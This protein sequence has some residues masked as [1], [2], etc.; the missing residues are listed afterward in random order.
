[1]FR[2]AT[3]L[4]LIDGLGS[5]EMMQTFI[6]H[7][8][9]R[10]KQGA[11]GYVIPG[12]R[13]RIV[14]AQGMP[15]APGVVGQLAVKGPSGCL[16]LADDRQRE[17]VRD[18]WNVEHAFA[19]DQMVTSTSRAQRRPDR[20]GTTSADWNRIDA[21]VA[22]R[23]PNAPS[24]ASRRTAR[25]DRRCVVVLNP[26]YETGDGMAKTCGISS[27]RPSPYCTA[28]D[29]VRLT[30]RSETGKLMRSSCASRGALPAAKPPG[31]KGPSCGRLRTSRRS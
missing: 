23:S 27:R 31:P 3:G 14:D 19:M 11:T 4:E 13:A 7:T 26:G 9:E 20:L 24:S 12:Y 30:P 6:S 18:G 17:Y 16:Y 28:T 21:A 29:R 25:A 8:P 5:T 10:A 15:C 2:K 22:M 1:M